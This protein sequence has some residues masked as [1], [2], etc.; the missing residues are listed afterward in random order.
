[1][2]MNRTNLVVVQGHNHEPDLQYDRV[3]RF[4]ESLIEASRVRPNVRVELI[5]HEVS[6]R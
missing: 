1:M 2:D 4:R 3:L 6:R 5:Y